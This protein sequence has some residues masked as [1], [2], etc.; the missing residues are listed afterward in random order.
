[1]HE[2]NYKNFKQAVLATGILAFLLFAGSFL[3][4]KN[5]FFLLLNIDL[6][7]AAD[8]FFPFAT[9]MGDGV[10]W[11]AALLLFVL[12]RR[13]YLPLLISSFIISEI[14][15]QLFK[16]VLLPNNPRPTKAITDLLQIHT[17]KGIQLHT[18]GSFPSGHTTAA[19]CFFLMA[20]LTIH[21]KWILPIGFIYGISVAYSRVY[22]AQ[23]FPLDLAGGM[24]SALLAVS[25][26]LVITR[27][28]FNRR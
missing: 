9:F 14:I 18:L 24:M 10:W 4:G 1:M 28:G 7:K 6:G 21:K 8:Y 19:F 12:F 25:L 11:L 15:I 13:K 2:L 27:K 26:G 3:A 22:L 5:N 17:V 20:S 23:H 16:S